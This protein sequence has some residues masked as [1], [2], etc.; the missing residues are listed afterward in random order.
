[1]AGLVPA[2]HVLQRA[3]SRTWMP[4][5]SP[6]M[7]ADRNSATTPPWDYGPR[8]SPGRRRC[9]WRRR[10]SQST[11]HKRLVV[12]IGRGDRVL[13]GPVILAVLPLRLVAALGQDV[14]VAHHIAGIEIVRIDPGQERHV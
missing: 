4:G 11:I 1:M 14:H 5:T 12:Q 7:T 3:R 6:G 8:R 13:L 10:R 9:L 2:I